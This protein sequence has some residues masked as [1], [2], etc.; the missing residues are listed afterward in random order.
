MPKRMSNHSERSGPSFLSGLKDSMNALASDLG[1]SK[2]RQASTNPFGDAL[3]EASERK[4]GIIDELTKHAVSLSPV[5]KRRSFPALE[6]V[7]E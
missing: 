6:N 1:L 5:V 7:P 4:G 3:S 2:P